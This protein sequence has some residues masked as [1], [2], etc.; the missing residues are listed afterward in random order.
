MKLLIAFD[1]SECSENALGDLRFAGLPTSADATLVA[2]EERWLPPSAAAAQ[3]APEDPVDTRQMLERTARALGSA[4]PSWTV[5]TA[6]R[7]GS[8]SRE[9][10][11]LA[12][13]LRPDL[14]VV[15]SHGLSKIERLLLGSVSHRIV[16]DAHCSVRVARGHAAAA[17]RPVRLVVGLDDTPGS[18]A[19]VCAVASRS[20]PKGSEVL[21]F[22]V[23][24]ESLYR[25]SFFEAEMG[26][27][28]QLQWSAE[29]TLKDSG[30]ACSRGTQAGEP[31]QLIPTRA[32]T[33]D[34]DCVFVGS[35]G[36]GSIA[37]LVLGSVATAVAEHAHCSVE[38]IRTRHE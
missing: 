18:E 22:T 20:W 21:I 28:D 26:R 6:V 37:R 3:L 32:K 4:F 30:L 24:D 2:V 23:F 5:A 35:H 19:A 8:P 29:T 25:T 36:R 17:D 31:K 9:V 27:I 38:V 1:G 33:F 16:A 15:G 11:A 10:L 14:V 34:A 12:E 7:T 13:E